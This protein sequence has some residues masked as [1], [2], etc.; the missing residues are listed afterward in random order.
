[1]SV[2]CIEAHVSR[3]A[4]GTA[5]PLKNS[6]WPAGVHMHSRWAVAP[7]EFLN[8]C[9]ALAGMLTVIGAFTICVL[10]LERELDRALKQREHL[11]E[12]VA[13]R[14]RAAAV[15]HQHVDR[16]V[17]AVGLSARDEDRVGVADK[18]D[19]PCLRIVGINH[20]QLR[21]GSSG[22]IGVSAEVEVIEWWGMV[23]SLS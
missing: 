4:T 9:G 23:R 13:M 2:G 3:L 11:L 10:P 18:G 14:R 7:D 22:G 6:S 17:P 5:T 16:A 15:A 21:S 12:V 1:M 8:W 19:V 20:G